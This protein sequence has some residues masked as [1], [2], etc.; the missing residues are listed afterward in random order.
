MYLKF[1]I[2]EKL[3]IKTWN[4]YELFGLLY[5]LHVLEV[6]TSLHFQPGCIMINLQVCKILGII[7]RNVINKGIPRKDDIF[8]KSDTL[9]SGCNIMI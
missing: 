7:L 4:Q 9:N 8:K 2:L 1:D 6:Y 3:K 5:N